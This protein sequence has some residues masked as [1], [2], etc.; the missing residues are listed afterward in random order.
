M[1]LPK[2]PRM[3][4][5]PCVGGL[6]LF[7]MALFLAHG[8]PT[9]QVPYAPAA[10]GRSGEADPLPHLLEHRLDI[11]DVLPDEIRAYLSAAEFA[12]LEV[13][14]FTVRWLPDDTARR[15]REYLDAPEKAAEAEFSYPTNE[16]LAARMAQW[17]QT[18]PH[19]VE[20]VSIGQSVQGRDLWFARI[21]GPEDAGPSHRPVVA[22]VGSMHGDE[23][24]GTVLLVDFAERL[25]GGYGHDGGL[26][27]LV[28]NTEIWIMPI[29]NP[30]GYESA[31]R[32]NANH[33]DLNRDFPSWACGDDDS[34][35][36]R[37]PETAAMMEWN[38][39][40]QVVLQ[41]NLH[42]G[43]LVVNYPFDECS[44][45]NAG[46]AYSAAHMDSTLREVSLSWAAAN[47][48]MSASTRFSGGITNG[49][50]WYAIYGSMQ[51]WNYR[52]R[53][54]IEVTVELDGEKLPGLDRL[55]G[56]VLENRQSIVDYTMMAHRGLRGNVVAATDGSP[57]AATVSLEGGDLFVRGDPATGGFHH[58]LVPGV[59]TV[60]VEVDG[61]PRTHRFEDIAVEEEPG[62]AVLLEIPPVAGGAWIA[63]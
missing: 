18:W 13:A 57:L 37:Q 30:D 59:Y 53:G 47:P 1:S 34:T 54:T 27:W 42:G 10:I 16:Q 39:A 28:D 50:Q 31:L 51:D 33:V 58:I 40:R 36:G 11:D 60:E 56:I 15:W 52:R 8:Q 7:I 21:T 41:A 26:T 4:G 24:V 17:E 32:R 44:F 55:G 12:R 23:K 45:C 35:A 48:S 49:A 2:R 22:H 38:A 3:V 43:E 62:A 63:R 9:A 6:F 46:C 20:V 5:L 25:M 19:L 61:D 14:G 29:M